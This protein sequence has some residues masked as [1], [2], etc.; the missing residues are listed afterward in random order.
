MKKAFFKIVTV[1]LFFFILT[2]HRSNPTNDKLGYIAPNFSI[3]NETGRIELQQMKGKYV[4]L[5]FWKSI[6]AESRIANMQ[7]DRITRDL[8]EIDYVAVNFDR[9]YGVYS[10][11]L[12]Q[13]GLNAKMQ[14]YGNEGEYSKIFSR[15]ELKRGMKSLLIDKSGIIIAENPSLQELRNYSL[16][17]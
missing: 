6:D 16:N 10:E 9:S 5:T 11:I 14:Y 2:A 3:E 17:F 4:L 13:D 1:C 15:Y 7:Y 12:K 8:N